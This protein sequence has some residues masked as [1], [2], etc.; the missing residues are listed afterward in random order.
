[1]HVFDL[2]N[3]FS[4]HYPEHEQ[5]AQYEAIRQAAKVFATV[6]CDNTPRC[7]DQVAALRKVREA[8]W[9]ANAS[10]ALKGSV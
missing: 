6:I 9:T 1:M 8:V 4:Y 10:I 5:L 7:A 3:V 2:N